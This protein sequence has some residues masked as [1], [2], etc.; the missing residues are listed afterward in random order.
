M[1]QSCGDYCLQRRVATCPWCLATPIEYH[2][3]AHLFGISRSTVCNIVHETCRAIAKMLIKEYIKFTS[4]DDLDRVVDEFKTKWVVLQCFGDAGGCHILIC[5]S[6][7]QHTDYYNQKG[8]YSMIVQGLIDADYRFFDFCCIGW[9]GNVQKITHE[10]LVPNKLF[11]ECVLYF[12]SL[13][14]CI[15]YAFAHN[16][17]LTAH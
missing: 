1:T 2:T 6:G 5:A 16:S 4:G 10:H 11:L 12:T 17:D 9:P 8:W 7:E 14:F 13:G 3:L 15:P